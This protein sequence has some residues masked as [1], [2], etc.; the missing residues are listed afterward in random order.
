M[1]EQVSSYFLDSRQDHRICDFTC[2]YQGCSQE[3]LFLSHQVGSERI[4]GAATQGI[5]FLWHLYAV[6]S[7]TCSLTCRF[8]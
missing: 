8:L 5:S 6:F 7:Y 1:F 2:C 4:L 3:E